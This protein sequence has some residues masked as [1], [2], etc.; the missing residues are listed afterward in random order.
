MRELLTGLQRIPAAGRYLGGLIVSLVLVWYFARLLRIPSP[1]KWLLLIGVLVAFAL[2]YIVGLARKRKKKRDAREF[3]GSLG[4]Q[5]QQAAVGKEEIREALGELAQKWEE[6]V[7]EF[8]AAGMS[9]YDLPWYMLIGEPQSGKSTTIK[10]S[11]LE[12]PVGTDSLSGSGGTRNC[13]WWF[14]NEAVILDTAGRFT[15][16]EANAPDQH[17]WNA[18]LTLIA[19]HRKQCP[20]NGVI[21]VI[22]VTS[23]VEDAVDIIESKAKNIRQKLQHLQ[24][25]LG[26]RFPV[27]VLITK[28]DRILGFTEFF[29]KL[30]PIDQRQLFGW[31]S[32]SSQATPWDGK[33]FDANF[34]EI[35]SR[36]HKLRL[37]FFHSEDSTSKID[38]LFVFPE[39]LAALRESLALYLTTMFSGSRFE[40]PLMLRGFYFTSGIQQGRPFALAC[41]ELLR[42]RAGDPEGVLENL[43][44]VFHKSRAFFI[45]DFYEKKAFPEQ[46][47]VSKTREALKK[48]KI[49]RRI[50]VGGAGLTAVIL[51]PLLIWAFTSLRSTVGAT[52]ENV[53]RAERC[54]TSD[55]PCSARQAYDLIQALERNKADLQGKWLARWMFLKGR[56]NPVVVRYIPAAQ[57]ALFSKK[58]IGPLQA[59]FDRRAATLDWTENQELYLTFR[60]AFTQLLRFEEIS[61]PN[62][63]EERREQ[64]RL[65]LSVQPMFAFCAET[66]GGDPSEDGETID[67]WLYTDMNAPNDASELFT[68]VLEQFPKVADENP[69]PS[70][71]GAREA[72]LRFWTVDSLAGWDYRLLQVHLEEGF[73]GFFRKVD[74]LDVPHTSD[75]TATSQDF[76]ALAG[77]FDSSWQGAEELMRTGRPT[78]GSAEESPGVSPDQWK[79][80]CIED[81]SRVLEVS[82]NVFVLGDIRDRCDALP[83]DYL[84]LEGSWRRYEYLVTGSPEAT[85]AAERLVWSADAITVYNAVMD[86]RK[87]LERDEI[88]SAREDLADTLGQGLGVKHQL[89]EINS[90]QVTET[91]RLIKPVVEIGDLEDPQFK[92]VERILLP[93]AELGV[94]ERLLPPVREFFVGTVFNPE[95]ESLYT[96]DRAR[97]NV[98]KANDFLVWAQR[99]LRDVDLQPTTEEEIQAID[100]AIYRYVQDLVERE[101]ASMGGGGGGQYFVQPRDAARA[102]SWRTFVDAV[103]RW[104][105]VGSS[106]GGG[107]GSST[108]I[109]S[110]MLADFAQQNTR[111]ESL[112]RQLQN[113]QRSRTPTGGG[114]PV[115]AATLGRAITDFKEAVGGLDSN[116]REAWGQ[117][118]QRPEN[119]EKFHAFSH[120]GRG[121][122]VSDLERDLEEHGAELLKREIEPEFQRAYREYWKDIDDYAAGYFPFITRRQLEDAKTLYARGYHRSD[123]QSAEQD[124]RDRRRGRGG[125]SRRSSRSSGDASW[126]S[127]TPDTAQ[128]LVTMVLD[129][130]TV[131]LRD[132][133][134]A[135]S[136][137]EELVED[138]RLE[139][140]LQGSEQMIDFIGPAKP[141]LRSLQAWAA[142]LG[143]DGGSRRR[144]QDETFEA[145]LLPQLRQGDGSFLREK[146]NSIRVFDAQRTIRSSTEQYVE[147]PLVMSEQRLTVVGENEDRTSGWTGRLVIEGGDF[148]LPYFVLIAADTEPSNDRRTWE[149]RVEIPTFDSSAAR[150]DGIFEFNF[151]R[152]IPEVLPDNAGDEYD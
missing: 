65:Y 67:D 92:E 96:A 61:N 16:Q 35:F 13:D 73:I 24:K 78:P 19:K 128:R 113:A 138:F 137:L 52:T 59:S 134:D 126:K 56:N 124:S 4:L 88:D 119:L 70:I 109:D 152:A 147:V 114:G 9:I 151:D 84:E 27:F 71:R 94:A 107:R 12:F 32:Q 11:G 118:A 41:K 6:A 57:A 48:E 98:P 115:V 133:E 36:V 54:L 17:E 53:Q 127:R 81:F 38:K 82:E 28:A 20:I 8:R 69:P 122:Y 39:E 120:L 44:Q 101:I 31:S 33:E 143:G 104:N 80:F 131:S 116:A 10:N 130:P 50:L 5:S 145:R 89:D 40:E 129:L 55:D 66:K 139:P 136:G 42:V 68:A 144:S 103:S 30:D 43:E 14:T 77:D 112:S 47:L 79:A 146:V 105:H 117:L 22:P 90:A 106:R 45:R 97:E 3:E 148:K 110:R 64:L 85:E 29:S 21:V 142:V 140:I 23:L 34:N 108:G 25:A 49:R 26:I 135:F 132:A 62:T 149:V 60:E 93:V 111:L 99:N 95:N 123:R 51:I 150:L 76:V 125:D 18:F 1:Y 63:E 7:K 91:S 58:I 121:R 102:Q 87:G 141:T 15:F 37:K 75:R 74:D 72:M 2:F 83:R 86:L 46:G 100:D